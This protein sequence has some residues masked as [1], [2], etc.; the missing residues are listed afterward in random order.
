MLQAAQHDDDVF[1]LHHKGHPILQGPINRTDNIGLG[2]RGGAGGCVSQSCTFTHDGQ[3][4]LLRF[5]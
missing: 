3:S 4:H 5:R 2:L 1:L